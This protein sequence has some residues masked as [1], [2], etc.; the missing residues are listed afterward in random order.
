MVERAV[1]SVLRRMRERTE[2]DT[3]SL[4]ELLQRAELG[5]DI[6]G[7][8]AVEA[9]AASHVGG[10]GVDGHQSNVAKISDHFFEY[11]EVLGD[12]KHFVAIVA[13]DSLELLD[14]FEI[15][16]S[17]H[18]AGL[19]SILGAV[20]RNDYDDAARCDAGDSVWP[21]TS[22]GHT[23]SIL[24]VDLRLPHAFDSRH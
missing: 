3:G 21:L 20:L 10:D 12:Q 15:G 19:Q 7:A 24:A 14:Q 11:V 1:G 6:G 2:A 23:C 8:M 13:P 5:T 22:G 17:G 18:E 4:G 9:L 16:V